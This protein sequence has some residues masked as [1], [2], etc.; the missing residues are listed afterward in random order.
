MD[1]PGIIYVRIEARALPHPSRIGHGELDSGRFIVISIADPGRGMDQATL[2]RIFEPF[3]TTRLDGNGLG[4]ATVR[5]IVQEHDGAVAVTSAVGAGTRFD[6][7]FPAVALS[8]PVPLQNGSGIVGRGV[9]ET[10]LVLETDRGRLLRNEEILAALGYEPVG[11]LTAAD[12]IEAYQA[13]RGRFDAALMCQ[14]PGTSAALDFAT[15]LREMAPTLPIILA[16]P[17]ARDLGSQLLAA[18][19]ISEVVR[20]PLASAELSR[21][22]TR[23]LAAAV[24]VG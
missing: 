19:G 21:V 18:S 12:A 17:S 13:E 15:A 7:W 10:V 2:A 4:L 22:L 14:Q 8:E 16:T 9:G 20:Y 24:V 1:E 23:C 6:I 11:F 5:E 3:F